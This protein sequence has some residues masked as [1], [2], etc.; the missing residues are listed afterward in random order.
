MYIKYYK[1]K[2]IQGIIIKSRRKWNEERWKVDN[3]GFDYLKL[4]IIFLDKLTFKR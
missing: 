4:F 3:A 2:S 1:T